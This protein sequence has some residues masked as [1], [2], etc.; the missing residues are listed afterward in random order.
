MKRLLVF[1][2][3]SA[4]AL[5]AQMKY[6]FQRPEMGSPFTI[7]LYGTDSAAAAAAA[8]AAFHKAEELN[9]L[10]SDYIDS[11]EINRLSATSGQHRWVPVSPPLFDILR[12]SMQ[13]ARLSKGGYDIT[14]G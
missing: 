8:E 12:Q 7:T 9:A 6:V 10:L 3:L 1:C 4:Q 13:A 11:S 14:V 5:H 2:L